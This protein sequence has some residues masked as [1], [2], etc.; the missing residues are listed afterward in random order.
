MDF[1]I[2]TVTRY[3]AACLVRTKN[4]NEIIKYIYRI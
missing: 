1:T 4:K 2:D 3:S